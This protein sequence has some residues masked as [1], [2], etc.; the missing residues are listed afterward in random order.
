MPGATGGPTDIDGLSALMEMYQE[1]DNQ[2]SERLDRIRRY[3]NDG[4]YI[5]NRGAFSNE[6]SDLLPGL[7][8]DVPPELRRLATVSRVN[9]VKFVINN[10]V[11][12]CYVDGIKYGTPEETQAIWDVLQAN[13]FT[14]RQ[15]GVHRS[16]FEYGA[17]Y[18][19]VLPGEPKPVIRGVSARDLVAAYDIVGSEYPAWAVW[20]LS[21]KRYKL[22]PG[23]GWIY[24]IVY[25]KGTD[26]SFVVDAI[27]EYGEGAPVP[28]IRYTETDD[29][30]TGS[31]CGLVEPLMLSQDQ[32]NLTSF[33]IMVTQHYQAFRQRYMI[34]WA[35]GSEANRLKLAASTMITIDQDPDSIQVGEFAQA[36]LSGYLNSRESLFK[37]V[38]TISQTPAHELLGELVNLSAEALAAA[39]ANQRRA[40]TENQ[41]CLGEAHELLAITV[42]RYLGIPEDINAEVMWRDT[43][44]RSIGA[45]ADA[46]GKLA[47]ML[48]VPV[49]ELWSK[50]PGVTATE[51]AR[52]KAAYADQ[53]AMG[54]LQ[55]LAAGVVNGDTGA[56]GPIGPNVQQPAG[57]MQAAG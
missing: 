24:D 5:N 42:A 10:R 15:I 16:A 21:D 17:S 44:S 49:Q 56:N 20:K 8:S 3:T 40:I 25:P 2:Q 13:Q 37:I 18:F 26:G 57:G 31:T 32:I 46:L 4:P 22:F 34:G 48:G 14:K 45:V 43:E 55:S 9:V 33:G 38:A 35:A 36:D 53:S 47:T 51:V 7:P 30:D 27:A 54:A 41:T 39:E 12:N 1:Y 23:D 50:I 52:W 11:Q 19:V 29:L 6:G 28:V